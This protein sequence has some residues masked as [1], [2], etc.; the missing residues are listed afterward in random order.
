MLLA[1][2]AQVDSVNMLCSAKMQSNAESTVGLLTLAGRSAR[3]LVTSTRDLGRIFTCMHDVKFDGMAD[4]VA[5]IQKAQLALKHRQNTLQ[6]QRIV[7]FVSSPIAADLEALARLGK[8]LKKNNVA[9]DV[10]N[11]G[12]EGENKEKIDAFMAAVNSNDNSRALHVSAGGSNLA[13]SLMNS[14][15]YAERGD[16]SGGG[17][18][19]GAAAGGD[20]AGGSDFPFGVDPT[21]DPELAMVLRISME[22]DLARREAE[23]VAAPASTADDGAAGADGATGSGDAAATAATASTAA[24]EAA[25]GT[26]ATP[27]AAAAEGGYE[28]DDDLYG[29]GGGSNEQMDVDNV[30]DADAEMLRQAIAMSQAEG[31]GSGA[32][33]V[34]DDDEEMDEETRRAIERS[35]ADYDEDQTK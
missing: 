27:A 7:V 11:I 34:A 30:E 15:I 10:V 9:V 16:G 23:R 13:D 21:V 17:G 12:L 4:F 1:Q 3:I 28:E 22:E 8:K 25:S 31:E 20:A 6:R 14:E 24:P 35:K 29:T 2:A 33:H 18:G 19:G 26:A 5:G 32:A